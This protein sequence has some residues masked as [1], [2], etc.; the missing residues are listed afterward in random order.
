MSRK[1]RDLLNQ[2]KKSEKNVKLTF[3]FGCS[4]AV[5]LGIAGSYFASQKESWLWFLI[6]V[7]VIPLF[8]TFLSL[9]P[10][11]FFRRKMGILIP[12]GDEKINEERVQTIENITDTMAL[13]YIA[14]NEEFNT[15]E[16]D[17]AKRKYVEIRT[18]E[19]EELND[20]VMQVKMI[21][22]EIKWPD[23]RAKMVVKMTDET[24]LTY[25][26]KNDINNFV[27]LRAVENAN[28]ANQV[29]LA[30]ILKNEKDIEIR[31]AAAKKLRDK[32]L[33]QS[34]FKEI[35]KKDDSIS[36]RLEA[37]KQ[38][39]DQVLLAELATDDEWYSIRKEA[40]NNPYLLDQAVLEDIARTSEEAEDI[41]ISAIEK[42]SDEVVKS[43][44][45]KIHIHVWNGGC[46]CQKCNETRHK[47]RY[48]DSSAGRGW[49]C[50]EYKCERCG[51][52]DGK[53]KD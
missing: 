51:E 4:I 3:S 47:W 38:L 17:T 35:A 23:V 9:I 14:N 1:K 26:A 32:D 19:I 10:S 34:V 44:L 28:L 27:R 41:R 37:V 31:I 7:I 48:L 49:S 16:R 29:V 2:F 8:L 22:N 5:L 33:S 20:Q 53:M 15:W 25:F 36:C 39:T 50:T 21:E 46:V 42:I 45:E 12:S 11:V 24:K 43:K 18:K 6:G 13:E 30:D 52:I 40:V